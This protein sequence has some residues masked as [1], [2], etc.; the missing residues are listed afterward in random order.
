MDK[1]RQEEQLGKL[2]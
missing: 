1:L 2:K